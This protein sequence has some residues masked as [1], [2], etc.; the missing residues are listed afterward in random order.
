M[1]IFGLLVYA[2]RLTEMFEHLMD[3]ERKRQHAN[4]STQTHTYHPNASAM[5]IPIKKE[6]YIIKIVYRL[7]DKYSTQSTGSGCEKMFCYIR[8]LLHSLARS[9]SVALVH[10]SSSCSLV[11]LLIFKDDSSIFPIDSNIVLHAVALVV[12]T[13]YNLIQIVA[14]RCF[15][16][17]LFILIFSSFLDSREHTKHMRMTLTDNK[18]RK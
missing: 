12:H 3:G 9:V 15:M 14:N 10:F 2:S 7:N 17:S 11:F 5:K 18:K 1:N 4:A 16:C 6:I 13:Q 8:F